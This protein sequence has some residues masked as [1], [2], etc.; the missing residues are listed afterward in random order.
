[1]GGEVDRSHVRLAELV[2]A[3]SLG[4]DLGFGQPMEHVLRQCLIALRIGDQLGLDD[5]QR[6]DIYYTALLIDVGCHTDAHEQSKWFG[7]DIALKSTK[8]DHEL[9]SLRG[10]AAA[11]RRLGAG[12]PPMHRFRLGLE[13]AI[14]GH[15]DLDDM[16]AHHAAIA[17][18]LAEQLGLPDG[19]QEALS[20][21]YEQWDGKGW[22]GDLKGSEVPLP[23]RV[24]QIA[25]F[26]E[27]AHRLGGIEAATDLARKR[28]GGQFD[29]DLSEL[30]CHD[31]EAVFADLNSVQTWDAVIASEPALGVTLSGEGFDAALL[32]I[33]NFVDLKSP[34]TLGH[35]RAV[36]DLAAEAGAQL[37][38]PGDEVRTLRRA[39]LVHGLGRLSVSNSIWDKRGPLG[40]GEWERVRL[41]PYLTQRML[42]HSSALAP[43]G[44]IA[45]QHRERQDGSGYPQGLSGAAILRPARILAA[46]DAYQAMREPRPHRAAL[47]A[48]EAAAELRGEV[49]AGR[50]DAEA[51]EAVLGAA[52]HR[53]SRRRAG[54]AGLTRREVE[55]LRLVARGMSNKEV[56]Q[57]L[58]ISP[59]T[60]ANHVEHIY[61]KIDASSRAGASLFAMHHGLLPEEEF[62]ARVPV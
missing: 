10:A 45:V 8:Y 47:A 33:A 20:G 55:V 25:E 54:P 9:G 40:L 62:V 43:L 22:P 39:G 29:P 21:A 57:A 49:T 48:D 32:A 26:V 37:G 5:Q 14:G 3:L 7:D 27:V 42:R 53:V 30:V 61:S 50:L 18:S 16:A 59:K 46:A 12:S 52:G 44:A 13:F 56:A 28:S 23:A 2:A 15:R 19:V 38:L 1:M 51:T 36:A 4:V 34:Y 35:A 11:M 6:V 41:T 58:V 60:V 17:A 24:S 31:A